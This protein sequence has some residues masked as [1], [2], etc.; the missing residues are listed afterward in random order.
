MAELLT[1]LT[2]TDTKRCHLGDARFDSARFAEDAT[3]RGARFLGGAWFYGTKFVG[4]AWFD[5]AEFFG[6]VWFDWAKF[7]GDA[8]FDRAKFADDARFQHTRFSGGASFEK[9]KFSS[10]AVFSAAKF[11]VA[12]FGAQFGGAEFSGYAGFDGVTFRGSVEFRGA[13]FEAAPQLGPLLCLGGVDLS[14]AVFGSPVII[15]VAATYVHCNLTRWNSTATLRLRC[16]TVD[17][18]NAVI[19]HPMAITSHPTPF[20]VYSAP[21]LDESALTDCDKPVRVISVRGADTAH[22]V[23]TDVDLTECQF[24]GAFHLDQLRLAGRCTF[25][26]APTGFHWRHLLPCRWT[27]RRTLVEEHYWRARSPGNPARGW[28]SAAGDGPVP[29]DLA[30]IYRQLRKSFED[31]KN[32]PDAADFYYGEME[33]RRH[34]KGRPS[35]ERALVLLYWAFSGYGLR[36]SRALLWLVLAMAA[37]VMALM[38]WGLPTL[39]PLP[40]ATGTLTSSHISL[41]TDRPDLSIAGDRLTIQRA[42]RAARVAVNAVVFRTSG[43]NLTRAGTYI[44]MASRIFEPILL[45]LAVLAVRGRVKR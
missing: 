41:R 4:D 21:A 9:A 8:S 29:A 31:G 15:E 18:S 36:A 40:A 39:A 43:Q 33:M 2:D 19:E 11:G 1:A 34:D 13:K 5:R 22:L 42:D 35:A 3:F 20:T 44:E 12:L 37:T 32:E 10:D 26:S 7:S 27:S 16:A 30:P 28:T 23:L 6:E 24:V 45:A 17:L 38:A 25:A 14:G